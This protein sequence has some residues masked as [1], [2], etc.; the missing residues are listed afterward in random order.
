[1]KRYGKGKM[2]ARGP[3][4]KLRGRMRGARGMKSR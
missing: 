2:G 4:A 3:V 1:M